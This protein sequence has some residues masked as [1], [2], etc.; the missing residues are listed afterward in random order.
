VGESLS[1]IQL[2]GGALVLLGIALVKLDDAD[3]DELSGTAEATVV[4]QP[5]P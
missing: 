2:V 1:T 5:E 3:E 4:V